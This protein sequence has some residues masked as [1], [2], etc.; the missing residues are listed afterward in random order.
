[1]ARDLSRLTPAQRVE[2]SIQ[3]KYRDELWGPFI[4]GIKEYQLIQPGDR[5]CVCISGGKDSMLLAKLMQMLQKRSDFPFEV[6]FL[7][8][9]PGYT[10]ENR[11]RILDN[12]ALLDIPK[13]KS[14]PAV[15]LGI[16]IATIIMSLVSYGLLGAIIGLFH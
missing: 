13:K 5:V 12:A 7:V 14:V 3:K 16:G 1:M 4:A 2:R 11:Q 8:M 15:L 10:P 9:D 6:K